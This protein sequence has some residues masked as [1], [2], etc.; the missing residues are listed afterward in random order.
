MN[1][2]Y[3]PVHEGE[4]RIYFKSRNFRGQ[5][6]SRAKKNAKFL[7]KTF[8]FGEFWDKFCGKNFRESK[9]KFVFA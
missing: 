7:T 6:L 5:K 8:A 2:K 3:I 4:L 9:K 1:V